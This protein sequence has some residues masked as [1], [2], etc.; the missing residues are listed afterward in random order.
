MRVEHQRARD[1]DL[2]PLAAGEHAGRRLGQARD[3]Q[4][5]EQRL[6]PRLPLLVGERQRL[7]H[8]QQILL[9]RELAEDRRLLRQIADPAPRALIERQRRDIVAAQ[10]LS[11]ASSGL[12]RPT[13]I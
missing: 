12:S 7:Q 1:L 13:S 10:Q 9:D 4:F 3:I 2:A 5:V 6:Q 11:V 8:R